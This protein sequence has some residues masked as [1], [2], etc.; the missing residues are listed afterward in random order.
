MQPG[1]GDSVL[2]EVLFFVVVV[3]L[4][5]LLLLSLFFVTYG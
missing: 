4:G 3:N 1:L 2:E 5:S